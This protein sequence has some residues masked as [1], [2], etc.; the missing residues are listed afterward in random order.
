MFS[1]VESFV[2]LGKRL[3]CFGNDEYTLSVITEACEQN[4]WFSQSDIC[5]AIDA[6][7]C[8]FLDSDKLTAWLS[9]YDTSHIEPKRVAIIMAGN[10]PLVG[11]FDLM[12]VLLSGHTALVKPSSKDRV[13]TD[14]IISELKAIS[15]TLPIYS[16][17]ETSVCDMVIATG[18][19]SAAAYFRTRFADIPSLVRGSRH[20][21]AV[22]G[23]NESEEEMLALSRD[24]FT[25]SGLGCRN[26]SLVM[27]PRGCELNLP[28]PDA[29]NEM[30]R[31]CYLS[32]RAIMEMTAKL[33]KDLGCVLAIE[34][35]AFSDNISCV[36]YFYYDTLEQ[37]E[38]WISA[39]DDSIQCIVSRTLE[40]PRRVDFGMAQYP[41]LDDYA[42]GVDVMEFLISN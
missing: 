32:S 42:D 28:L 33:Y 6:I 37:V 27:L 22:L 24:I 38:E 34:Q 19:D 3:Q 39:N 9:R 1:V 8:Q 21:L 12:C 4:E 5:R 10:I 26:V 23:G 25:Y 2:E 36:N 15:P 17:D 20:S 31:G 30:Y 41:A 13:L 14:Y 11:F 18:G 40:H 29:V 7:R 35:C 16:Y